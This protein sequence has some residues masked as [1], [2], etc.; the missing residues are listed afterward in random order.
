[1]AASFYWHDY[2]T[3]GIDPQRDRACQFA[4]I[5]TD[6]DFNILGDP[7]V[8]YCRLP[9]DCLPAP[10][11]CLV[12]G[13]TPQRVSHGLNEAEF[14]ARIHQELSQ[15]QTCGVGYNSIRFDDEI[16]RNLLYRNF[17]DPYAR[18]WQQ[19]NS[20][21]DLIDVV[22]ACHALRPEGIA[23]PSS[24]D[25]V[26]SLKLE[27]LSKAN[28]I[29]HEHAHDALSDVYATIAIAKLI[30]NAQPKLM[31][32]ALSLRQ[33]QTV[34]DL[35]ALGQF[36]PLIHISG[37][38]PNKRHN[39]AIILPLCP[40]PLNDKEIC[41]YDLSVAPSEFLDLN[42]EELRERLFTSQAN[43][44]D[45][46]QRLPIKTLQINKCPFIAPINVLRNQDYERLSLDSDR[47]R[48][49]LQ[50][51]KT[52]PAFITNIQQ[53]YA[54]R[55]EMTETDPELMIYSGGFFSAADKQNMNQLRELKPDQIS[56]AK[57]K[58]TDKRLASLW[59]RYKARNWP[60]TL[61]PE[62]KNTWREFCKARLHQ[63]QPSAWQ[64]FVATIQHLQATTH[65][66]DP[67]L[68]E[69][70]DYAKTCSPE[71]YQD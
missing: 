60:E 62:E 5:R 63:G 30:R 26:V 54:K 20:R 71:K 25:G 12:T 67:I 1:M 16:T 68:C 36:K 28:N 70:L 45:G 44:L 37:R 69:L 23:W 66:N 18:E 14:I 24:E 51:L 13:L 19:Q 61:N 50:I 39:L 32:F 64:N 42:V 35:L 2:E 48:S 59:F 47:I 43:L 8:V 29:V 58:F 22:R 56:S 38:Y 46:I 6:A 21:W 65:N 3:F 27:A 34:Q 41:V 4:G 17:Y 9:E 49:H 11:A 53:L 57:P 7:L 33:K 40:H 10:E 52:Q 55:P 31:E 15:A